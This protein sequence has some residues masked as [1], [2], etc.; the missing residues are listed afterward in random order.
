[1]A[2]TEFLLKR[3]EGKE[4]ELEKLNKKLGRILKA[5]ESNWE[6]NPYC[7]SEY[8]KRSTTKEIEKATKALETYKSELSK[9][10]EKDNSRNVKAIL[11]FLDGW[12]TRVRDSYIDA[13]PRFI[14]GRAEWYQISREHT[15]W[16]NTQRFDTSKEERDLKEKEYRLARD[17]YH[18]SWS[19]IT[20]YIE[21]DTLDLD[22][23]NKD[24]DR[25]ANSKYDFIIER[26]NEIVGEITDATGLR[27]GNKGDLNG[28]IM[29][30]KG[31]ANVKTIGAGGYNIQI[32]HF[33]T[34]ITP[35]K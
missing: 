11:D 5:E 30:T 8:D 3:V 9:S 18:S 23:L 24:L 33:R 31:K 29:G 28:I 21:K 19:W 35:V 2:T 26:T 16:F 22:K 15:E 32:Y 34:L 27:I 6:N 4:K 14:L 13:L 12:K 25:E 10:I 17:K 1:M 7:Y 20:P